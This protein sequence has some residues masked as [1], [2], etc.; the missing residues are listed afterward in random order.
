MFHQSCKRTA[1]FDACS[2][3]DALLPVDP[4]SPVGRIGV[5]VFVSSMRQVRAYHYRSEVGLFLLPHDRAEIRSPLGTHISVFFL[6]GNALADITLDGKRVARISTLD[7]SPASVVCARLRPWTSDTLRPGQHI[8]TATF[9]DVDPLL[10][11]SPEGMLVHKFVYV[12]SKQPPGSP[13]QISL[14]ATDPLMPR[15]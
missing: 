10:T 7:D 4:I 6:I 8:L 3:T 2:I 13:D 5:A 14:L 9:A 12:T 15:L 1:Q 11:Y